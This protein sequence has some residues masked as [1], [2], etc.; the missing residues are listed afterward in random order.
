MTTPGWCS[1]SPFCNVYRNMCIYKGP[2]TKCTKPS[3]YILKH[4]KTKNI[5][6]FYF[7]VFSFCC[8][9]ALDL[10]YLPS[11]KESQVAVVAKPIIRSIPKRPRWTLS[12]SQHRQRSSGRGKKYASPMHL[13][14]MRFASE[15]QENI[16]SIW[17]YCSQKFP[18]GG[19]GA[20][21]SL[22]VCF[23]KLCAEAGH[24][25]QP[26]GFWLKVYR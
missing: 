13:L 9:I 14:E 5:I 4:T 11:K 22:K 20:I 7:A 17:N 2:L 1:A 21:F 8:K 12:G 6:Y 3:I 24:V 15:A 10:P 19:T 26:G 23:R 18:S 25:L 16:G